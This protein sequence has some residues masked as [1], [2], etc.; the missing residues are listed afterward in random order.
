MPTPTTIKQWQYSDSISRNIW[1]EN[2]QY[3]NFARN[4]VSA[5][6]GGGAAS[7]TAGDTN[8]L[9]F[10]QGQL[11]YNI[12]GTQTITA[13]VIANF[14]T[15][16]SA[17]NIGMDQTDNDGVELCPG[18]LNSNNQAF[19]TGT[20]AAFFFS[21]RLNIPDVSGTDDLAIGFREAEA[22]QANID[23]YTDMAVLNVISGAI[24]IETILNGAATVSTDTTDTWADNATKQLTVK[25]SSAGVVTYLI[26]GAAPTVTAAY[27][28]TSG[29]YVVP[30]LF[31]LHASDVAGSVQILDWECGYQ[32]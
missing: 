27:T 2:Y 31:F 4:P 32:S 18:I 6:V 14:A 12:K 8:V 9:L 19:K 21:V 13:P 26:D 25:V 3:M 7:G 5:K 28:F 30:F 20:D 1:D 11:E 29:L 16:Q 24:Y 17:L 23:D 15:G 22:Y 10:P